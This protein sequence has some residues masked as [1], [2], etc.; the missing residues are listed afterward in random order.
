[1]RLK[2]YSIL[3]LSLFL[4]TIA[5]GQ[6][7]SESPD[8]LLFLLRQ[9]GHI[10]QALKTVDQLRNKPASGNSLNTGKV[11]IIVCGEAV[12]DFTNGCGMETVAEAD[13]LNVSLFACGLSMKKY[14]L[15][16]KDLV[17]GIQYVDN[18]FIKAFELQ[19]MGYLSVEL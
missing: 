18:G 2:K 5:F 8:N 10:T 11:A 13:R 4:V 6:K 14:E 3:F 12:K 9:P 1:M 19:K 16:S 17:P 15:T 7:K